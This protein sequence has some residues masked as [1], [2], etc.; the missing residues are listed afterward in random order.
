MDV[1]KRLP[2]PRRVR[3]ERERAECG[4]HR[5]DAF[6]FGGKLFGEQQMAAHVSGIDGK[7]RL[8]L[9]FALLDF[10]VVDE[11]QRQVETQQRETGR[12]R[13]GFG[14]ELSATMVS[15]IDSNI[16][17]TSLTSSSSRPSSAFVSFAATLIERYRSAEANE[18]SSSS[19]SMIIEML[20]VLFPSSDSLFRTLF[21]MGEWT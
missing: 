11:G 3:L 8:E 21:R 7:G 12:S 15:K 1:V 14:L 20:K 10:R 18:P 9:F 5:W 6:S 17:I 13:C 2:C 4:H 16:S 19:I